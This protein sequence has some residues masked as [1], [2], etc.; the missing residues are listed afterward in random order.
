MRV[1][2]GDF[3]RRLRLTLLAG[4][5][6][7]GAG[8]RD[9]APDVA[10][11]WAIEPAAPMMESDTLARI[12]LEDGR[13]Q[14]LRGATL[15]LEAHMAHP[16]MAPVTAPMRERGGGV[17]E[18]QLQF[19]MAGDWVLVV[20]GALADGSRFTRSVDVTGVRARGQD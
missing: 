15:R 10:V 12:T 17:Y 19:S 20:S 11:A 18:A 7:F 5:I 1:A 2:Q 16:G 13:R 6:A 3:T 9:R 4:A 14:R 8:C